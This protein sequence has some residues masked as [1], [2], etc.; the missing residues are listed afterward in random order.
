MKKRPISIA[1]RKCNQHSAQSRCLSP[2]RAGTEATPERPQ[3]P[4]MRCSEEERWSATAQEVME[5][6]GQLVY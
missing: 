5:A 2:E 3:D 4:R 1:T 6:A